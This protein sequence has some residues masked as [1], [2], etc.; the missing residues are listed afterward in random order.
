MRK[1]S[2]QIIPPNQYFGMV[3]IHIWNEEKKSA[4]EIVS[5]KVFSSNGLQDES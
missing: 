1:S 4:L 3:V 2:K 5:C